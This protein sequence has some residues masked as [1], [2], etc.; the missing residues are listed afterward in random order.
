MLQTWSSLWPQSSFLSCSLVPDTG[1]Y[2]QYNNQYLWSFPYFPIQTAL[3][4]VFSVLWEYFGR[5]ENWLSEIKSHADFHTSRNDW[6]GLCLFE[7]FNCYVHSSSPI[8]YL[9]SPAP[10]NP[11]L[12]YFLWAGCFLFTLSDPFFALGDSRRLASGP[13]L[14]F[15][16]F[17]PELLVGF[18]QWG[19]EA[20]ST[21][22][23]IFSFP[24][25]S[26]SCHPPP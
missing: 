18:D 14:F 16:S 9:V 21:V 5:E 7:L 1:W 23:R 12:F 4:Y 10:L 25:L 15:G 8:L 20:E 24:F 17:E 2:S 6:K 19:S 22:T 26:P 3:A 11:V 13:H